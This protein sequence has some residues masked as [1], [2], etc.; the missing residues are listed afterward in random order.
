MANI[1]HGRGAASKSNSKGAGVPGLIKTLQAGHWAERFAAW[2]TRPSRAGRMLPFP[3]NLHPKLQRVLQDQG[4]CELRSHQ[5]Q[6]I[7][8]VLLG[9]DVLIATPTASGKTLCYTLPILQRLLETGGRSRALF[10]YPTKAL[11]QDQTASL[12]TLVEGLGEDWHASTYD[13]DTP[14]EVRRSARDRGH[15]IL[16][17]PHM[18]HQGI[19]P[20]HAKWAEL[21]RDLEFVVVDEVHSLSG[22]FGSSVAC[23]LRR[24]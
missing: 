5:S 18:L 22:V 10:L 13:G 12:S 8:Q 14:V 1:E 19:L 21:F 3:G 9:K 2:K 20:N 24:L 17:N 11:A 15:M 6:A 4:I 16:T 23:V 7:E